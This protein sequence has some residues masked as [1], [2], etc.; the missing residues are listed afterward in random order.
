[1]ATLTHEQET[2]LGPISLARVPAFGARL[3]GVVSVHLHRHTARQER[4][5]SQHAV[6]LGKRPLGGVPVGCALLPRRLFGP[7][8]SGTISNVGQLFQT[9]EARGMVVHDTP[10]EQMVAVSFQ[11]SLPPAYHDESSCS[12]TGAFLLQ[13]FPESRVMV[14][15]GAYGFA[16]M[17]RGAVLKGSCHRQI[18]LPY[19]HADD[20][21][22]AFRCR[23]GHLH[24]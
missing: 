20:M 7:L 4:L 1:M 10:T 8:P 6:Q 18:P 14:S 3:A 15:F 9:E 21:G 11:P 2:L 12:G 22:M 13:P 19:V 23:V 16:G 5:I 17:E 24:L